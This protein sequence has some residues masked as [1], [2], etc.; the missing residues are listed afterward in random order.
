M[1]KKRIK[2]IIDFTVVYRYR[3]EGRKYIY[4]VFSGIEAGRASMKTVLPAGCG[5]GIFLQRKC[6]D[7][8]HSQEARV[9]RF[10]DIDGL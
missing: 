7:V 4:R 2:S 8:S 9:K 6:R 10:Y 3:R 5:G 1:Q